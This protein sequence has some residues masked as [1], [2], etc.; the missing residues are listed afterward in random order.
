MSTVTSYR[1]DS[2]SDTEDMSTTIDDDDAQDL[3]SELHVPRNLPPPDVV[4]SIKSTNLNQ[5]YCHHLQQMADL[6]NKQIY[7]EQSSSSTIPFFGKD[8]HLIGTER[9]E[10]PTT[11]LEK[12]VLF[13]S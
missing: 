5:E 7:N 10:Q 2:P 11:T 1:S 4:T 8:D 12:N 6:S 13:N 9:N 3:L